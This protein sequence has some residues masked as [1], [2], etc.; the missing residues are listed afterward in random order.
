MIGWQRWLVAFA[1]TGSS[2][3]LVEPNPDFTE[4]QASETGSSPSECL[5]GTLDCDDEP[6]CEASSADPL[7]CG[8]CDKR[9][10]IGDQL[11]ECVVGLCVGTVT[12]TELEDAYTDRDAPD[13]AFGGEPVLRVDSRRDAYVKLPDLAEFAHVNLERIELT[14]PCSLANG[15]VDINRLEMNWD[16][17]ALTW[18]NA[19]NLVGGTL[20][21][22]ESE[23]GDNV[24]DLT[25]RVPGWPG[26]STKHSLALRSKVEVGPSQDGIVFAS[27]ES[28]AGP[29]LS[30]TSSW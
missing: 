1:L 11:L 26:G 18:N 28:G 7:S 17:L 10:M 23:L 25:D 16:E 24:I 2:A 22:F 14:L 5:P 21:S 15:A 6:G 27:R 13:D 8:S 19:P 9:C 20:M 4:A 29:S 3:C 30:I 12:L